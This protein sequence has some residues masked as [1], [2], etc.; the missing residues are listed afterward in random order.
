MFMCQHVLRVYVLTC[1][2]S[3]CVHVLTC[4]ACLACSNANVFCV[5]MC[6]RALHVHMLTCQ[7]AI[8]LVRSRHVLFLQ[9]FH[10]SSLVGVLWKLNWRRV[11]IIISW[12]MCACLFLNVYYKFTYLSKFMYWK[13]RRRINS[14]YKY[15]SRIRHVNFTWAIKKPN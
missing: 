4:L 13:S 5:L 9:Y 11:F 7:L 10:A 8:M 2:A 15:M 12:L 14:S 1:L 3:W 6:Q